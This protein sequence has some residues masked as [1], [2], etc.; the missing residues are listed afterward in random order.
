MTLEDAIYNYLSGYAGLVPLVAQRVYPV[1]LP[2]TVTLPAVTFSRVSRVGES[3][4]NGLAW[5]VARFQFSCWA[6]KHTTA[7]ATAA[8]VRA[9][10]QD[11]QGVMGGSGGIS[12][13]GADV[14]NEVD[15]YSAETGIFHVAVDVKITHKGG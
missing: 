12:V 10:F 4:L 3:D 8:Q 9:A 1:I 7:T 11:Y 5:S 14:V 2:Q 13:M 15:L 6:K